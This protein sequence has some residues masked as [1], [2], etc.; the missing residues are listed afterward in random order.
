MNYP[1]GVTGNEPEITGE[2]PV[3]PHAPF[4]VVEDPWAINLGKDPE[5]GRTVYETRWSVVFGNEEGDLFE[6]K[7]EREANACADGLNKT[8]PLKQCVKSGIGDDVHGWQCR[9]C[10][11]VFFPQD[12]GES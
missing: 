3:D 2:W 6:F 7:T 8:W 1:P 5:N 4:T 10:G 11:D 12:R 9:I